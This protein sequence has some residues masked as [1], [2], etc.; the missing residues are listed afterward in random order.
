MVRMRDIAQAAGVSVTTV[1]HV[2]NESRFVRQET[3][4]RVRA[5]MDELGYRPNGLARSL[6]RKETLTIGFVVPDLANPFFAEIGRGLEEACFEAGYQVIFSHTG[7]EPHRESRAID[8]LLEKQVEGLVVAPAVSE[9]EELHA[10]AA[11]GVPVVM[12]DRDCAGFNG[13]IV[14]ANNVSGGRQAVEHLVRLGHRRIGCVVSSPASRPASPGRLHGYQQGMAEA[15]LAQAVIVNHLKSET[16]SEVEAGYQAVREVL[17]QTKRPTALFLTNDLMAIG[18][19]RAAIDAGIQVPGDLA[20]VGFDDIALA[21]YTNPSLTTVRQPRHEMGTLAA[22]L[23][24]QR[25]RDR[26]RPW[27]RRILDV[28]LVARESSGTKPRA[29]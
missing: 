17:A 9:P 18:A 13:D 16:M 12:V 28:G 5:A 19:L 6:R 15:G 7:G 8:A 24:V 26:A 10:L 23:I 25:S 3:T 20:V 4:A 27:E 14:L 29:S 21:Q 22:A 2:L 11:V 1:S